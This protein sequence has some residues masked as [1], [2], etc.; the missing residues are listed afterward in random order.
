MSM[1]RERTGRL[2]VL[3]VGAGFALVGC[4]EAAERAT[5]GLAERAIEASADGDVDVD[6]DLDSG[7]VVIATE[8]GAIGYGL[9]VPD[10]WPDDVPFPDGFAPSTGASV[11]REGGTQLSTSGFAPDAPEDLADFYTSALSGWDEEHRASTVAGGSEQVS[12]VL[13]DGDRTLTI[14]ATDVDGQSILALN[15]QVVPGS[16]S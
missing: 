14:T 11:D 13:R 16:G 2:A 1:G 9:S 5:Q 10:G 3:L 8:D 15:H 7:G 4:G 6:L 12:L